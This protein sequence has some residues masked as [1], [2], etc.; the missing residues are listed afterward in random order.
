MVSLDHK[1]ANVN[2]NMRSLFIESARASRS[3]EGCSLRS[4]EG[5]QRPFGQHRK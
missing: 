4:L 3:R 1:E 5:A 2:H